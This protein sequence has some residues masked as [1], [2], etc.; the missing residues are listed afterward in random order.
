MV[1]DYTVT[2]LNTYLDFTDNDYKQLF[3]KINVLIKYNRKKWRSH[4][5]RGM[6]LLGI[7]VRE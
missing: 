3:K 4:N 6:W 5:Y 2:K 1:I 7:G